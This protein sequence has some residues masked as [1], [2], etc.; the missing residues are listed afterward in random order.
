MIFRLIAV[1][2]I[3]KTKT[4]LENELIRLTHNKF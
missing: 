1:Y 2:S 4:N 3:E